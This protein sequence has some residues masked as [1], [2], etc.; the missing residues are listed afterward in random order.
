M[1]YRRGLDLQHP[2]SCATLRSLLLVGPPD[3]FPRS[4]FTING[5]NSDTPMSLMLAAMQAIPEVTETQ[6]TGF[7][8]SL[9]TGDITSHDPDNQYSR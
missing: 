6:G 1:E 9:F 3:R 2:P 7:N 5:D 4:W 8:F